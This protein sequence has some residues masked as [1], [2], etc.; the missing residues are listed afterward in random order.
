MKI[1]TGDFK[2]LTGKVTPHLTIAGLGNLFDI[3]PFHVTNQES[4]HLSTLE[5]VLKYFNNLLIVLIA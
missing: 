3:K 4:F 5:H 1:I 2:L